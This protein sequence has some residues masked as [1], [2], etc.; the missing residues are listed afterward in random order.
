MKN[1][2]FILLLLCS[3]SLHAKEYDWTPIFKKWESGCDTGGII[4]LGSNPKLT[5]SKYVEKPIVTKR[6]IEYYEGGKSIYVE[7]TFKIKQGT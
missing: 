7:E 2:V 4:D 3:C 6:E 1:Y 5:Y